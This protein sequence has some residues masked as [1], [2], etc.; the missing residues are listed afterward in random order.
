M[1]GNSEDAGAV[2]GILKKKESKNKNDPN[3]QDQ[4]RVG[5]VCIAISCCLV[6]HKD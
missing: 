6:L 3:Y 4:Q 2:K 5:L 1:S